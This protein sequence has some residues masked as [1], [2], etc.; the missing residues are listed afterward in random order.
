MSS[1]TWPQAFYRRLQDG[2]A[3]STGW[4]PVEVALPSE[5]REYDIVVD[6]FGDHWVRSSDREVYR[7]VDQDDYSFTREQLELRNGPLTPFRATP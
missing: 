3:W 5:P 6:R 4:T 1:E 7:N 2:T